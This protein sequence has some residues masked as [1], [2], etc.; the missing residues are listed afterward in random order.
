MF[1]RWVAT[2]S[3]VEYGHTRDDDQKRSGRG[4]KGRVEFARG[5][6]SASREAL[7]LGI[8]WPRRALAERAR[9]GWIALDRSTY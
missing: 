2:S 4:C 9:R 3:S 8:A 5:R 6:R 7:G 1:R